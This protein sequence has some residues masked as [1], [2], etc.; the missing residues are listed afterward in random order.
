MAEISVENKVCRSCGTSIRQGALFCYHCGA[1]VTPVVITP[2]ISETATEN[3]NFIVEET[4][5]NV[6]GF[7]QSKLADETRKDT[8][9]LLTE[10]IEPPLVKSDVAPE[11]TLKSAASLRKKPKNLQPK[12]IEIRWE[13]YENAPNLRLILAVVVIAGFALVMIWL[14]LYS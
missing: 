10:A 2:E 1:V 13:G 5:A 7:D 9:P 8:S 12:K 6:S 11:K 14:A 3:Q 4:A